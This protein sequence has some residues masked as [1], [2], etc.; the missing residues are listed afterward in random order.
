MRQVKA[1]DGELVDQ[2]LELIESA[3]EHGDEMAIAEMAGQV[4]ASQS[5]AYAPELEADQV[6]VRPNLGHSVST[7]TRRD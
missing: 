6:E 3:H 4:R 2:L 7:C 1:F 5:V